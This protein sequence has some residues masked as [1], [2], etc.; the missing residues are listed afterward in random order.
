[1]KRGQI[2]ASS[3]ARVP[4]P[5]ACA[6]V[7]T[8]MGT[9][10]SWSS[11]LVSYRLAADFQADWKCEIGRWLLFAKQAGFLSRIQ[12]GIS[13]ARKM[14][15]VALPDGAPD[16]ND[17]AHEILHQELA[18]AEVAYY[19]T[20]N[21]WS[22][23][24][25]PPANNNTGFDV[26]LR[27]RTPRGF[28]ADIQIKASDRMGRIESGRRYD[29]EIDEYVTIGLEKAMAQIAPAPGPIRMVVTC[30]Q[31]TW[32][33]SREPNAVA[34]QMIGSTIG[35]EGGVTLKPND[36]GLFARDLYK[37]VHA[38]IVL[39]FFRPVDDERYGCAVFLNPWAAPGPGPRPDE[40]PH[41]AVCELVS[42]TFIWHGDPGF[43]YVVPEGTR[44][45]RDRA[46]Q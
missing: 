42:D 24:S 1:M 9:A 15:S 29:G 25:V 21:G 16:P 6:F 19:L 33:M 11:P 26:D 22:F 28:I 8:V 43:C 37:N 35:F 44:Y 14:R 39:D 32:P 18:P 7:E 31:R 23:V 10:T 30:P 12:G 40:F 3:I 20:A 13:R 38:A 34:A 17:R 36:R 46:A 4:L 27:M 45:L 2:S 41:A 5:Q